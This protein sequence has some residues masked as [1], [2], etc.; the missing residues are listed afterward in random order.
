[1]TRWGL[2]R[3]SPFHTFFS[4]HFFLPFSPTLLFPP[5]LPSFSFPHYKIFCISRVMSI[6]RTEKL[7]FTV[8]AVVFVNQSSAEKFFQIRHV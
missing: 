2:V 3:L 1:M 7:D 5:C 4:P 8:D 6:E